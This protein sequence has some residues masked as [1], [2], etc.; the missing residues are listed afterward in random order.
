[1]KKL[2]LLSLLLSSF[3]SFAQ[4]YSRAKIYADYNGL[5]RLAELGLP[6]DHG[7]IKRET[8]IISDFSDVE[9][10]LAKENGFIVDILIA[11]VQ[12]FY[13]NQNKENQSVEK[14]TTCNP[15]SSSTFDPTVPTNFNLGSMGG[16][17]TYQ[18]FLDEIDAMAAQYPTLITSKSP[19]STFQSIEGRPIYWMR[20]SDNAATDEAEPEVLYTAIHHAREANS[21]S[22]VIFYMWYLLEN[23]NSS[24]EIQYLIN[25]TEMYFVPLI[26]PD[27]YIY[28]ETI[29]PSGGGMW[30]KNRRN[31]GGSYGVDL[32][33]N[34]SY[35]WN[36]T[37][38]SPNPSN[39][40]YPG[41]APFSEPETQAIKWFCENR[42]FVYA[43]NAH[44]Y[45]SDILFPIGATSSEFA[46]DHDY[47]QLFTEEM[48]K[49]NNYSNYK[50]SELYP[51][52]GDSDDYMYKMDTIIK[53]KIFAMTPEVSDT[54]GGFWP[55]QSLITGI[56]KDMVWSNMLLAHLTHRYLVV[57]DTD[58]NSV[59]AM[60]GNFNHSATRI[61][62][63]D[64]PVTVSITPISGINTVG[65]ATVHDLA[66]SQNTV[67]AITY[68]LNPSIAYGDEIKYV[69]NT[70][71]IGWTKHD[72]IIKRFGALTSQVLDPATATTDWTGNFSLTT[73]SFVSPSS[74]FT[75]SPV[76]NYGSNVTRTYTY[77]PAI[78]LTNATEAAI[79]YYAKWA[80]ETDYDFVQFEVSTNNGTT[81][82]GQ[83]GNYTRIATSGD[84]VQPVGE[85][86]Y[87]GEQLTWVKEEISLSDYI[88]QTIKVRFILRSDGGVNEDGF[89]FDDFEILFNNNDAS[90][91]ELEE[92]MIQLIPN[93]TSESTTL[94]LKKQ[95][96]N[97]RVSLVDINGKLV[98]STSFNEASSSIVLPTE[99]L[100]NGL[101]TVLV[102]GEKYT[103]KTKLVVMH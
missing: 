47:F 84:G 77:V 20:L 15:N 98:Y 9:I 95:S 16:F 8:F 73:S 100:N 79:S 49:F 72:T 29:S 67:G 10:A 92:N 101:Y 35:Q 91:S 78:D 37:G 14:N 31:N 59:V 56:C 1:M 2:L 17:Y 27:G 90:I 6:I 43:F 4:T 24:A 57:E 81:W 50:S 70:E 45:A 65:T 54:P 38:V 7:T 25:N 13:I 87:D 86:I 34:Y 76:G 26:N 89:Y 93:P 22:E 82:N 69:L 96:A 44:T 80:L 52:S 61:G 23:Y 88:G 39:D 32:N 18:E 12:A 28:N 42:N 55:A 94:I 53:P 48:V 40:T 19:I 102:E 30:R 97:T 63:E 5:T 60:S 85:P 99:S 75:D 66:L 64:G 41:T 83:C 21:L 62:I 74:S 68:T 36:T 33:R 58:P 71:Y 51:A 46:E 103:G 11:D 3:Y